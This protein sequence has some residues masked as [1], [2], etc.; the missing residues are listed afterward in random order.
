MRFDEMKKIVY[1]I[2][3]HD[4]GWSYEVHGKY[5]EPFRT[6]EEARQ[7]AKL[8]ARGQASTP[9]AAPISHQ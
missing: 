9:E 6:R 8:A 3:R 2:M 7:A 5:S 4:G 1:K